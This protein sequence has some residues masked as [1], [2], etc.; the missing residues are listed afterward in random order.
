MTTSL[1]VTFIP[2]QL[3]LKV[4]SSPACT[5]AM[6]HCASRTTLPFLL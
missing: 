1:P 5:Q 2:P 6:I 4:K 3:R